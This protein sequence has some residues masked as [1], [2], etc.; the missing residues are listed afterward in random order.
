MMAVLSTSDTWPH[1]GGMRFAVSQDFNLYVLDLNRPL[2]AA[3]RRGAADA[4][5]TPRF[6]RL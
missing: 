1:I 2:L 3:A 5:A 6:S 4:C